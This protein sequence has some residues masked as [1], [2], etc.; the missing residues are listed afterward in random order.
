MLEHESVVRDEAKAYLFLRKY[1]TEE[2][3]EPRVGLHK[4]ANWFG[5]RPIGTPTTQTTHLGI[6]LGNECRGECPHTLKTSPQ[7]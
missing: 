3:L 7:N 4:V 1:V 5:P 6:R 2:G